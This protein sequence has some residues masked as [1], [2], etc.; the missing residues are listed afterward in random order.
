[1]THLRL[2]AVWLNGLPIDYIKIC[3][4]RTTVLKFELWT[5]WCSWQ[6][7]MVNH[8]EGNKGSKDTVL[9]QSF[10]SNDSSTLPLVWSL[11]QQA[12]SLL[13][14]FI[15]FLISDKQKLTKFNAALQSQNMYTDQPQY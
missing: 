11:N 4:V 13:A 2:Q 1:M 10:Y 8:Q 14:F 15:T 3:F 6:S 12:Y 7:S 9:M 5:D